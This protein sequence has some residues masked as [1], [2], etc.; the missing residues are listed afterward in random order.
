MREFPPRA[1]IEITYEIPGHP[2]MQATVER[3]HENDIEYCSIAEHTALRQ[4]DL[5]KIAALREALGMAERFMSLVSGQSVTPL[6]MRFP[7]LHAARTALQE[8]AT[9]ERVK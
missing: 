4:A 1:F 2:Y 8:T 6:E 7:E 5:E 3:Q 9:G